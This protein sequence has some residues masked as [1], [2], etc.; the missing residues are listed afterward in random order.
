MHFYIGLLHAKS[1]QR[2]CNIT[3][4]NISVKNVNNINT[5]DPSDLVKATDYYTKINEI[6]KKITDHDH[7]KYITTQ[8]FNKLASEDSA[9]RLAQGSFPSKNDIAVLVTENDLDENIKKLATK[10]ELEKIQTYA[11]SFIIG[12]NYLGNEMSTAIN[13]TFRSCKS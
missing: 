4:H 10:A 6:E 9:A 1:K 5:T 8:K 12:Q 13:P 11:S 3:L 7:A 2:I